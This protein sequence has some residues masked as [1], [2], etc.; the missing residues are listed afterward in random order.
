MYFNREILL[1]KKMGSA[2]LSLVGSNMALA[3][4]NYFQLISGLCRW[5]TAAAIRF[6]TLLE[7]KIQPIRSSSAYNR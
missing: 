3:T 1:N 7:K 2:A 4:K 6:R 5:Q